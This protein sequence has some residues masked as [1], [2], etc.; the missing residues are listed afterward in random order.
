MQQPPA[1]LCAGGLVLL[2]AEQAPLGL[3]VDLAE[4]PAI[5]LQRRIAR[6]GPALGAGGAEQDQGHGGP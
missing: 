4:L 1:G 2:G 3:L 6:A 5:D